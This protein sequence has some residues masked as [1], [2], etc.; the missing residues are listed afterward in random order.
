MITKNI[1]FVTGAS[2]SL[3]L[4]LV[5]HLLA[6]GYAVAATSRNLSELKQAVQPEDATHFLPLPMDRSSE[7]SVQEAITITI[8]TFGRLDVVVNNAG[9]GQVGALEEL[10]DQEARRHFGV[11]LAS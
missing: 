1:W 11:S 2:Q 7:Q 6:R 10:T 3:G 5:H 9:Y 4:S 8:S